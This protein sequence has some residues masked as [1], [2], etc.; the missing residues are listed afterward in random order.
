RNSPGPSPARPS[1]RT[2]APVLSYTRSRRAPASATTRRPLGSQR[3]AVTFANAAVSPA[4]APVSCTSGGSRRCHSGTAVG[5][6]PM[7]VMRIPAESLALTVAGSSPQATSS[8]ASDTTHAARCT[9]TAVTETPPRNANP[10][11]PWDYAVSPLERT[12]AA[13]GGGDP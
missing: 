13:H 9:R 8:A 1:D 11:E 4:S 2:N 3:T 6:S 5:R 10:Y 12:Q 7:V